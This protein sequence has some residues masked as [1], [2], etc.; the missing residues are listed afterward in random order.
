MA[1]LLATMAAPGYAQTTAEPPADVSQTGLARQ[2]SL[3]DVGFPDGIEFRRLSGSTT[4]YFPVGSREAVT[5][6]RLSLTF[7]HGRTLGVERHLTIL[8]DGRI[9]HVEPID[10]TDGTRQVTV[11]I[12]PKSIRNGFVKVGLEYSGA[13][14]EKIC[15]DERASGDFISISP[16]SSVETSLDAEMLVS[17]ADVAMTMPRPK[18][19]GELN[20]ASDLE[21]A[22]FVMQASA[23]YNGEYGLV[24][25][26]ADET[27]A[28][29]WH[30]G[31]LQLD[32]DGST[33]AAVSVAHNSSGEPALLFKGRDALL[34]MHLMESDWRRLAGEPG[35]RTMALGRRARSQDATTFGALGATSDMQLVSGSSSFRIPFDSTDF[36]AGRQP[37][38][39][40]LLISA[41]RTPE[42]GGVTVSV[43][44]NDMLLGNRPVNEDGP[45]HLD[46]SVP[47][48]LV[49]RE[50]QL[51]VLVQRQTEG[52]NCIFAPQGY[53][54]QILPESRFLLG[55]APDAGQD[56]FLMRQLF[57][58]GAALVLAPDADAGAALRWLAVLGGAL[59]PNDAR[60]DMAETIE[61]AG[62]PFIYVGPHAPAGAKPAVRFDQ[63]AVAIQASDGSTLY[64]GEGIDDIGLVQIVSTNGQKGI[65]IRPGEGKVPEPR[66]D[67]PLIL[68][69]G[70]FAILDDRGL[71]V[72]ASSDRT[73]LVEVVYPDQVNLSQLLAK[74]RPWI[75][76][77]AW[78]LITALM[79]RF[80]LGLYRSRRAGS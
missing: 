78:L 79:I 59:L 13:N 16:D 50:N 44:L 18:V 52:G 75:I 21:R 8:L 22:G 62:Q 3:A 33:G 56:F 47:K 38:S 80:L 19:V 55:D 35:T 43:F 30:T 12:P 53:P 76:G 49:G 10:G 54:V 31:T 72:A 20:A 26:A 66:L 57:G 42:G 32:A 28:G 40:A 17:P 71:V 34:A 23:I 73:D 65:W 37:E 64:E 39:L 36:P 70:N 69:R 1:L 46:F 11:E 2:I 63:G 60:L 25:L 6:A 68:D 48:G 9:A 24:S 58:E 5:S 7:R 14:S 15:V 41:T 27:D 74:Y 4:L 29:R 51:L 77:A 61:A 45:V 67:R